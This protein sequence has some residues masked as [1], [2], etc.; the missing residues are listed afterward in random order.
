VFDLRDK[1]HSTIIFESPGAAMP[2][3]RIGWNKQDPRYMAA[4]T[5]VGGQLGAC[6]DLPVPPVA[7]CVHA[8]SS[9]LEH[10]DT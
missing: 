10:C 7:S 4:V 3:L 6:R 2:L 1:E 5:Q 8:K 9:T